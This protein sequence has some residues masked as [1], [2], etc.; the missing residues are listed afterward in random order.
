VR[1]GQEQWPGDSE[2]P[3]GSI[4]AQEMRLLIQEQI[5]DKGTRER[6]AWDWIDAAPRLAIVCPSASRLEHSHLQLQHLAPERTPQGDSV[7]QQEME[8]IVLEKQHESRNESVGA[9]RRQKSQN[10]EKPYT[11]MRGPYL[12]SA[13]WQCG[14]QDF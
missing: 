2:V 12:H 4:V 14:S 10:L 3:V 6:S 9:N 8:M 1:A 13:P 7:Q 11:Q 5:W